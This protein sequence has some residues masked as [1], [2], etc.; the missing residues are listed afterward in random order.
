M[1][2]VINGHSSRNSFTAAV[3]EA[4]AQG[5]RAAGG[6]VELLHLSELK[7]DPI[8]H[9]GYRQIQPLEPDLMR[10]QELITAC[11][12]L[13]VCYP[14]WWGTG[15]ALLK[16]FIDRVFLPGFAFKYRDNSRF[17]NKLLAGRSAEI[18]LLSDSPR[19]YFLFKY[20]N[21][22]IEW[23]KTATLKFSGFDPVRVNVIGGVR[24]LTE[25]QRTQKLA[26]AAKAGAIAAAK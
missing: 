21:S 8:L 17:W 24:F 23:L 12:K 25:D 3:A 6:K 4:Y 5:A 2:L 22:P 19:I 7:F 9:E 11:T 20:W 15:P 16:G 13:V 18:W 14:Q 1:I 10:A 26:M